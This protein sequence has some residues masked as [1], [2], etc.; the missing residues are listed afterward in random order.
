[1]KSAARIAQRVTALML[2][3]LMACA[4][5]LVLTPDTQLVQ[6]KAAETGKTYGIAVVYDNSGSMYGGSDDPNTATSV[7]TDRVLTVNAA[8]PDEYD[9]QD[10][11]SAKTTS[12]LQRFGTIVLWLLSF[13]LVMLILLWFMTRKVLPKRVEVDYAGENV[14]VTY[15]RRKRTLTILT[16]ECIQPGCYIILKLAPVSS[17]FVS[18]EKRSMRIVGISSNCYSVVIGATEYIRQEPDLWVRKGWVQTEAET[19]PPIDQ[20][21]HGLNIVANMND[22]YGCRE[23][24]QVRMRNKK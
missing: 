23:P 4:C 21:V 19:P 16:K 22:C 5:L 24:L 12:G 18:S 8:T 7:K 1:M 2:C 11:A 10:S 9:L 6:T 15:D 3:V 13:L 14:I 17:R 20:T